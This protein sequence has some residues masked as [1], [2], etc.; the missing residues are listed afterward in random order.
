MAKDVVNPPS[1]GI[2]TGSLITA[3]PVLK[4]VGLKEEAM[5]KLNSPCS[6]VGQSK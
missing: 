4:F 2:C 1:L 3:N 5:E 6:A